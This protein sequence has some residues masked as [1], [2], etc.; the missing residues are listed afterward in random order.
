M[1]DSYATTPTE[2]SDLGH[3]LLSEALAADVEEI[4]PAIARI[5]R[6]VDGRAPRVRRDRLELGLR[7]ALAN[8]IVHGSKEDRTKTVSIRVTADRLGGLIFIV[9]DQGDGFDSGGVPNPLSPNR[10]HAPSGRGIFLIRQLMDQVDF[11][12]RGREIRMRISPPT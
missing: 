12:D 2:D 6:V 1:T 3:L 11:R 7:E 9:R 8:A 10:I 5:M 4:D